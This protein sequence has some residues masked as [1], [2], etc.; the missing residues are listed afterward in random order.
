[1]LVGADDAAPRLRVPIFHRHRSLLSLAALIHDIKRLNA[2][3]DQI[4]STDPVIDFIYHALRINN[5]FGV[6]RPGALPNRHL[7]TL[8]EPLA[9]WPPVGYQTNP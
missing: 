6:N 8:P 3:S 7:A 4:G 5:L 2:T 9:G 1:V